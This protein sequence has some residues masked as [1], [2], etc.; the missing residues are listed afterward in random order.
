MKGGE[1]L[2]IV[3]NSINQHVFQSDQQD[4]LQT[5]ENSLF[6]SLLTKEVLSNSTE[7]LSEEDIR[8]KVI[9]RLKEAVSS[10]GRKEI[11]KDDTR[12]ILPITLMDEGNRSIPTFEN[13][14]S[15]SISL[16]STDEEHGTV[17]QDETLIHMINSLEVYLQDSERS[18][19]GVD[20]EDDT[21]I[22]R[23]L[24]SDIGFTTEELKNLTQSLE[25]FIPKK[26]GETN[27]NHFLSRFIEG[28]TETLSGSFIEL[29]V[30]EQGASVTNEPSINIPLMYDKNDGENKD[31]VIHQFQRISR[32]AQQ[33]I[34]DILQ[35]KQTFKANKQLL[36]LLEQASHI[37]QSNG[38]IIVEEFSEGNEVTKNIWNHLQFMYEKRS[39]LNNNGSYFHQ[40]KVR[41]SD[42]GVWVGYLADENQVSAQTTAEIRRQMSAIEHFVLHTRT[43]EGQV[44]QQEQMIHHIRQ[45]VQQ[46]AFGKNQLFKQ[47]TISIQ[48]EQ[49]GEMTIQLVKID[50]EMIAKIMVSSQTTKN[51]LDSNLHQLKN[52]FAPHQVLIEKQ[53]GDEQAIFEQ[54]DTSEEQHKSSREHEKEQHAEDQP[55]HSFEEFE[56][57]LA[58]AVGE[59]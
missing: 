31:L 15:G 24:L 6:S 18:Y 59:S 53:D 9:Q 48:P 49:L 41:S 42:V 36:Q 14:I 43:K 23:A 33:L 39:S 16:E 10:S 32:D 3:A 7:I 11:V 17:I 19:I 34:E 5:E 46:S 1:L 2:N 52:M 57:I 25:S 35:N 27:E 29:H 30:H 56:Q 38:E 45:I 47:L 4:S 20:K 22:I 13:T 28:I 21:R 51:V 58:E 55:E 50:G 37:K 40:A 26:D 54:E 12:I 44:I 8:H